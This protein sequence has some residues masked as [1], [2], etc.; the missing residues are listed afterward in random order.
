MPEALANQI[1][2][3]EVVERPASCVKELVEN[4]LDAG[5]RSVRVE[6][7]EGGIRRIRV[8]DDGSGMDEQDLTLAFA[9]H[10]TSK[11]RS[12]RDLFRIATLGF[13][14]E[15][16]A[17]I[18]AV[19]RVTLASRPADRET[20][21]E[22]AVAGSEPA[23]PP[24]PV[25]MPPGTVMDVQ[26]LFYNTP[27]RLKY[28]RSVATERARCVEAVQRAALGRPDVRFRAEVDGR[29]VFQSPG[30]GDLLAVIAA[31]YGAG[32]AGHVLPVHGETADY[33]V[34][35]YIGRP[36]QAK[37]TRAHGHLF[38]NG[39]PIRNLSVHQAVVAGYRDRLMVNRH[40]MYVLHLTMDP[41]LVDVN[42]HPHKSEVRFSEERDLMRVVE[43]AVR[44]ALDEAFLAPSPRLPRDGGTPR[45]DR[46]M[47]GQLFAP[48]SAPRG[49]VE[50]SGGPQAV[51]SRAPVAR[52][53]RDALYQVAPGGDG[54]D[55][56]LPVRRSLSL[57]ETA[58]AAE[59][60]PA[61]AAVAGQPLTG[62][63]SAEAVSE[64]RPDTW[65]LRPIGQALGMYVIADDGV[66]LY[67]ID[68]HA[69]HERVLYER[70]SQRMA[71][72][73]GLR[74]EL[75]T[76]LPVHLTPSEAAVLEPHR[77]L[78]AEMGL[79]LEPFGGS[80]YVLRAIPDVWDGLDALTLVQE[81]IAGLSEDGR[82]ADV[83]RAI[84]DRIVMRACKAAIKANHRLS[85][86]EMHALCDALAALDDPFHCPHG[87]PV[88]LRLTSRQL[89]KEFRR[90]V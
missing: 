53:T 75:L 17:S 39:R 70:F 73:D 57:E 64:R 8:Q 88:F 72:E 58:A 10:A 42:I 32:E 40:P 74:V 31:L 66:D 36:V 67:V 5:A 56:A 87:R 3:G 16:L 50:P 65:Q 49:A 4:S 47:Q 26:D 33:Q 18:A 7:E 55:C 54:R 9:R 12:A 13:R 86:L 44:A 61:N 79:E 81:L 45:T 48:T 19:A 34:R 63:P 6:L 21:Y 52:E 85:D 71:S 41:A 90:I 83:K 20:G 25:G 78:L 30:S 51:G 59:M 68:Q 82:Q 62:E 1:A 46:P 11:I 80:D 24:V 14:G 35:G 43:E 38:I 77:P 69:A 15:A 89:E 84:R 28:L 60:A 29:T 23:G 27:A 22:V 76:P 37:A 2:A